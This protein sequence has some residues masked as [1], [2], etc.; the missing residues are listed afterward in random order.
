[1]TE[2][3]APPED[4]GALARRRWLLLIGVVAVVA[5]G[6][7]LV[8]RPWS[9]DEP[10]ARGATSSTTST[11]DAPPVDGEP[12]APGVGDPYYPGLGNGGFDVEH[13]TLDLTWL[14]DEGVLEGVTTIDAT[15]TQDLSRFDLDLSGL[16]VRA[17]T[18]EGEAAATTRDER[19]L[20]I[21]PAT[22]IA[23]GSDFTAIITY[24]GKPVPINEGTDI[25]EL[26]WQTDGREAFVV[27]EPSGAQTFFPVN[28][29][30]TDKATYTISVTAPEDQTVAANGLLVSENDTGHGTRS[31]TYEASDPMA[32]YLVQIAIGDYELVD[33]GEVG[34][35]TIR[36]AFHRSLADEA[37]VTAETTAEMID[38]LDDI[39]GP[40]P[41]EAYGLVAVAE[42]LGFALETQTLTIIGADI[43]AAGRGA[44]QI[45]VHELAHQWVGDAVSPATWKDIWLNEGFATYA[46]WLWLER[47]GQGSAADTARR[48]EG[49]SELDMPPGD[50]GPD[51]LFSGTVYLRGGMT[52][53]VLRERVGDDAFFEILRRWV[54]EH[55]DS[56]ASTED[57]IALSEE[58]SG[59]ELDDLFEAWLYGPELPDL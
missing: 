24:R 23:D 59:Q 32:S 49:E 13:Y 17:V 39:Y 2:P 51:E 58:V 54:V 15:A 43:A 19:E 52:L 38:L 14:A 21:D 28:D 12:G 9:D 37:A 55:R 45:L 29:H 1:V 53:Q 50:P 41:F 40:Y 33:A 18:V 56:T 44:D 22:D 48:F 3:V 35:V 34:N 31:W 36:H 4:A 6:A 7:L 46:E 5:M 26:G 42:D 16:E 25:F 27:S 57:F 30:P 8:A 10:A 20:V 11:T 47:T